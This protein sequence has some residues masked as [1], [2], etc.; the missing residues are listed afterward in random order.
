HAGGGS[1][2]PWPALVA[3][4]RVLAP[5]ALIVAR[6]HPSSGAEPAGGAHDEDPFAGFELG[7]VF[8]EQEGGRGVAGNRAGL[9]EAKANAISAIVRHQALHLPIPEWSGL[10]TGVAF[11]YN[12]AHLERG[13]VYRFSVNHVVEPDD[14]H[15]MF[16]M[17]IVDVG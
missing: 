11:P 16:P 8:E 9:G 17:E 14:A 15:E 5:L 10:I 4:V 1:P 13:L 3:S 2:N 12:P 6:I 7:A